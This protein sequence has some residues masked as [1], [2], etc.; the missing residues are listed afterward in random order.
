MRTRVKY[1]A[2]YG[3]GGKTGTLPQSANVYHRTKEWLA[4]HWTSEIEVLEFEDD[5]A[6]DVKQLYQAAAERGQDFSIAT[7]W[8]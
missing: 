8:E 4:D 2:Y 5:T 7:E 3:N 1:A 6:D